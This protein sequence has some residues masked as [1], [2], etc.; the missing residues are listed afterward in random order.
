M[1]PERLAVRV[2]DADVGLPASAR[3][4]GQRAALG[5]FARQLLVGRVTQVSHRQVPLPDA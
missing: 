5:Q 2:P 3:T 1:T 4:P